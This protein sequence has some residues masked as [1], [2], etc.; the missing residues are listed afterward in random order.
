MQSLVK[1][2]MPIQTRLLR[3]L[4]SVA[5]C[6]AVVATAAPGLAQGLFSPAIRVNQQVVTEF[7]LEQRILFM[8]ILN[9]PGNPERDAREALIDDRLKQQLIQDAGLEVAPEEVQTGI[10]DLASRADLSAEEFLKALDE[11][12]VSAQTVRDFVQIQLEW[13]DYI[14]ARY[15]SRARPSEE[16]IDRAIGQGGANGGLQVLLSEIILPV[17]PQTMGQAEQLAEQLAEI[18]SYDAFSSAATQYSAADTRNNGGRMNWLPL[19]QVP[20]GLRPLILE[21]S[22]GEITD[23]ITL[24]NALALFQ[25]RGI[26]ETAGSPP[27]YA[28]IDYAT[29]FLAGGRSAETL[30]AA[31]EVAAKVDTCDDLYGVAKGQPPE[32][33]DRISTKPGEIPRDIALELAKLDPGE[34]STS[35]TRSNGQTLVFLMLCSRTAELGEDA[36][37]DD[38][39]RSLTEQRLNNFADSLLAQQRADAVIVE[40]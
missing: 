35:L 2:P 39:A 34:V 36:S 16:E 40:Q 29:Y 25:M 19:T 11:V 26:R 7:E 37:R 4:A 10:D 13:R 27:R 6:A 8:D 24:P 21:L 17:T 14:A 30:A 33:L 18:K 22:P 23:P 31:A 5:I 20:P 1:Y 38:V 15:L 32:V 9:I 28:T 12:G 3:G